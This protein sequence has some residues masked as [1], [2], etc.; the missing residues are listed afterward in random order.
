MNQ[1]SSVCPPLKGPTQQ[2]YLGPLPLLQPQHLHSFSVVEGF[3]PETPPVGLFT[4]F[5]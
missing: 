1:L 2:L 4:F 3:S 5:P